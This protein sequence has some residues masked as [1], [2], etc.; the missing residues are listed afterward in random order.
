MP[1]RLILVAAAGLYSTVL[2]QIIAAETLTIA[3]SNVTAAEG[4]V[5][6]QIMSSEAE[7]KGDAPA[8]ASIMQRAQPGEMS[9]TTTN[10]P[11]GEYAIRVMHDI[12]DND[13]LDSN[14]VGMP[15]EPWGMSNNARGNFGPPRWQ[16]VKFD[17]QGEV[18]QSIELK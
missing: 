2:T 15:T 9:F 11:A 17:L 3:V 13:K 10:L 4:R 14:F 18:T 8:I 5:M 12:N 6:I 1:L 7:F 16:D